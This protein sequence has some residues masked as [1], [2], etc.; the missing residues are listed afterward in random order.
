MTKY[1]IAK[2]V[3]NDFEGGFWGLVDKEGNEYLPTYMPRQLMLKGSWISCG[4]IESD[5]MSMH[6]WGTPVNII[7][8]E[9]IAI[10]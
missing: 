3:Y 4:I 7:S 6:M 8:F 10:K 2:V 9:T 5:N 1:I